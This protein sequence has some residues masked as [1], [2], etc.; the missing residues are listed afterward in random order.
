MDEQLLHIRIEPPHSWQPIDLKEIWRH[1]GLFVNLVWR[2]IRVVYINTGIGLLWAVIEP[3]AVT[4]ILTVVLGSFT[5]LPLQESEIPYNLI[6]LSGMVGWIYFSKSIMG[7]SNSVL[8]NFSLY[9]K[10]YLP[11]IILPAVPMAVGLVDLVVLLIVFIAIAL[12]QGIEPTVRWLL[13][14][15]FMLLLSGFS[16]GLGL[17]VS[18]LNVPYRDIGRMMPLILQIGFYA[19]PIIYP[20]SVIS[21]PLSWFIMFNPIVGIINF[22]RW[23]FFNQPVFPLAELS[24]TVVASILLLISGAFVFRRIEDQFVDIG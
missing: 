15:L 9:S 16:L 24:I 14:P 18:A 19:S 6:V 1:R 10:V 4:L 20:F 2:D 7:A 17:W 22:G 8:A 3:L 5:R 11:R 23:M 21:Q 13:I 12:F